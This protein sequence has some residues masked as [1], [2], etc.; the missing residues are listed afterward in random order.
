MSLATDQLLKPR[1][2]IE[3]YDA[4]FHDTITKI[5]SETLFKK[6]IGLERQKRIIMRAIY[7]SDPV[8]LIVIGPPGNGKTLLLECIRDAFPYYSCWG[9][10]VTSSG[11]GVI[12]SVI[13]MANRLR[14]L[15]I[16][17]IEKFDRDDRHAFLG[18][19][20]RGSISR[21]LANRPPIELSGLKVWFMAT[22]N[23][24]DYMK[25]YEKPFVN[26]CMIVDIPALDKQTFYYIASKR[27]LRE[28]GIH[29]EEIGKYIAARTYE[30]LGNEADIRKAIMIARMS[31]AHAVASRHDDLINKDVVDE[32]V[33][34]IVANRMKL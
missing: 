34:D 22:C 17:E 20:A 19:L 30:E 23:D 25:K 3:D 18:L 29:S 2:V 10:T 24:I 21:K 16:D 14:F 12:E 7:A 4:Q 8:H 33:T 32:V 26:R 31:N 15:L 5:D 1:D 6:V 11:I 28:T 13:L 27:L 9:D